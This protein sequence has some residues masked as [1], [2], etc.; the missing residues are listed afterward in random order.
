M[1]RLHNRLN[2]QT[3]KE[4]H[5]SILIAMKLAQRK[6]DRYYSITDLSSVYRIAMG[7]VVAFISC[8]VLANF[9][10]TVLHP[11][12]KLEYFRQHQWDE[13]WIDVAENLVREEYVINYEK[14]A[15]VSEND[16]AEEQS[17]KVSTSL[18]YLRR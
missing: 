14:K 6:L 16:D 15:T 11:G 7:S 9:Y 12:L 17:D 3:K 18:S 13:E 5:P 10:F 1:D 2:P 8:C 4:Y